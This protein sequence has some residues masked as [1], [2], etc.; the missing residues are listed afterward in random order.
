MWVDHKL[1]KLPMIKISSF[2]PFTVIIFESVISRL[3]KTCQL[4]FSVQKAQRK[5]TKEEK[6]GTFADDLKR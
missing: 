6:K 4:Y 1:T 2:S 5:Q 3:T